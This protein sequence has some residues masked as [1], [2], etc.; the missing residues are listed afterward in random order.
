[1]A[2][3]GPYEEELIAWVKAR[4]GEQ[5]IRFRE[6]ADEPTA[7]SGPHVLTPEEASSFL[8]EALETLASKQNQAG[9][10]ILVHTMAYGN[11]KNRYAL[12]GLLLRTTE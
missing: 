10:E 1:M 4:G 11:P 7:F 5:L 6:E 9:I 12:A 3:E 2:E 8:I